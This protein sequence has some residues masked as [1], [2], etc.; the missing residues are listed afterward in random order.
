MAQ[1]NDSGISKDNVIAGHKGG[2]E[3]DLEKQPRGADQKD[4][5]QKQHGDPQSCLGDE[6]SHI[7]VRA[8]YHQGANDRTGYTSQASNDRHNEGEDDHLSPHRGVDG[9]DKGG[10][11]PPAHRRQGRTGS[12]DP[13]EIAVDIMTHNLNHLR[14]L[15]PGPDD[16]PQLCFFQGGVDSQVKDQADGDGDQRI[17]AYDYIAKIPGPYKADGNGHHF[18]IRAPYDPDQLFQ[19]NHRPH[20]AEDLKKVASIYRSDYEPFDDEAQEG[21]EKSGGDEGRKKDGH[22]QND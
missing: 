1:R 2:E 9:F 5:D 8:P 14:V 19:H 4:N 15:N 17:F 12:K 7:I 20:R 13:G 18:I 11:H 10:P 6:I 22:V 3:D 16:Q 21:Y